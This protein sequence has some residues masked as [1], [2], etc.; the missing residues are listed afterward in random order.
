MKGANR[1]NLQFAQRCGSGSTAI[2]A[3]INHRGKAA[4]TQLN[5]GLA[6][7]GCGAARVRLAKTRLST[8]MVETTAIL[9]FG[10]DFGSKSTF[11]E[12]DG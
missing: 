8:L 4:L 2:V 3:T 7:E 11:Q 1:E 9:G 12:N 6:L 5:Q 10:Y